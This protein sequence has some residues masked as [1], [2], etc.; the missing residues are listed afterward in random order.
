MNKKKQYFHTLFYLQ[1]AVPINAPFSGVITELLVEDG[2]T[3][4]PGTAIFKIEA[5]ALSSKPA[6]PAAP[7]T[8]AE[9]AAPVQAAAPTPPVSPP[10]GKY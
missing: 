9:P 4:A 5:K 1:T 3:V 6:A 2:A 8:Q 10:K 7:T